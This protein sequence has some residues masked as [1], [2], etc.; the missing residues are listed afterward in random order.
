LAN[1]SLVAS[2]TFQLAF[3]ICRTSVLKS[4]YC[5]LTI[6]NIKLRNLKDTLALKAIFLSLVFKLKK[7]ACKND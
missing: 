1:K 2:D 3:I 4:N 6:K 5:N 7:M